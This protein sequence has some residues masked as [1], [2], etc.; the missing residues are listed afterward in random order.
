MKRPAGVIASGIVQLLGSLFVLLLSITTLLMPLIMRRAPELPQPTPMPAGLS[1]ALAA[2]YGA[3]AVLGLLTAFGLFR[4]KRW[5]RYSTIIFAACLVFFG[6]FLAII[7]AVLPVPST[8]PRT[9]MPN[10]QSVTVVK[11][12]MASISLAIAALGGLW[13]YY[14]NRG[15]IKAAFARVDEDGLDSVS[16]LLIGG[17]RVP[18]SIASIAGFSLFGALGT[19]PSIVWI[20]SAF[21]FGSLIVGKL[22]I[23]VMIFFCLAYVYIG[24]GVLRL[25]KS[26]RTVG[27][28]FNCYWLV[29]VA[30]L[31][32]MP[33]E[34]LVQMFLKMMQASATLWPTSSTPDATLQASMLQYTLPIIRLSMIAGIVTYLIILY[35]LFTRKSAFQSG[36]DS[37]RESRALP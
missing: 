5:A 13:L 34:R 23:P 14:F 35:F 25:W 27:I 24:V 9:A 29:N 16:G 19:I 10:P 3:F 15:D 2:F 4:L 18:L 28:V 31:A 6:L 37:L 33:R 8:D 21:V 12:V 7:F 30:I 26:G 20:P 22:A 32:V 17:R 11:T 36:D 1:V